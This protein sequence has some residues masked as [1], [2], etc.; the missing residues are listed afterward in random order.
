M[1][2]VRLLLKL[3]ACGCIA[4][5]QAPIAMAQSYP[6]RV[7]RYV[8]SDSPGSGLDTLAR[9]VAEGLTSNGYQ[10][11]VDNRPGA[12]GNIG[13][14]VVARAAPDGYTMGQIATTHAVNATLYKSLAYDLVRDFTPVTQLAS[15]PSI[16][17]VPASSAAKTIADLVKLA[18]ARPGELTYASAG[19]GTCT[20]LAG[21]L[22]KT[23][24]GVDLLHVAYKGGP[25]AVTS[26]LSGET[27]V[28]FAPLSA[29]LPQVRAGKLRAL[30]VSTPQRLPLLPEFPTIAEAGVPDYRF[31]CWYGLVAPA[32][33][34]RAIVNTIHAAVLKVLADPAAQ[35]RLTDS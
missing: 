35:K 26:V 21:E 9:I 5:V 8:V 20:F 29:A 16:A 22:F 17:V 2:S 34:P 19:T 24:A 3:F 13:A 14:E 33:T 30:G 32:K 6:S 10:I 28:Y 31:S 23:Q 11:V 4:A 7:V 18:K 12:G 1:S 27:A 25:P 15:I